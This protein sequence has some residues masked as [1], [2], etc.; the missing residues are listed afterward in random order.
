MLPPRFY[1]TPKIHKDPLKM[2]PILT[3]INSITYSLATHLAD[4]LKAL[5]WK[6]KTHIQ[7][8]KN[9]VDKLVEVEIEEVLTEFAITVLSTSVPGKEVVEMAVKRANKDPTWYN[10]T[11]MTPEEFSELLLLVVEMTY[12]RFQGNIF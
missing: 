10:R 2:R 8:S 4:L 1:A 7:N 3:G 6:S 12:L 5:V 11:L 9:L